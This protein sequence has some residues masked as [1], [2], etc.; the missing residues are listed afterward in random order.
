[1]ENYVVKKAEE[2]TNDD[3]AFE[4][5]DV[6]ISTMVCCSVDDLSVVYDLVKN[7]LTPV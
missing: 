3:I 6:V 2:I 7:A 4:S 5:F 1:V